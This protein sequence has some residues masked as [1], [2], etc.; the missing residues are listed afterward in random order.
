MTESRGVDDW[1]R[2]QLSF[3]SEHGAHGAD[4]RPSATALAVGG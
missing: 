3:F 4:G 2:A 1:T